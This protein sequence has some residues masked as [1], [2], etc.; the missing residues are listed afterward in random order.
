MTNEYPPRPCQC[1][2]V[3]HF[4]DMPQYDPNQHAYLMQPAGNRQAAYVGPVCDP[5]ANSHYADVLLPDN[6]VRIRDFTSHGD[7]LKGQ[8]TDRNAGYQVGDWFT[9]RGVTSYP[10]TL[11]RELA[12]VKLEGE[13]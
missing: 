2:H 10:V 4:P 5:C 6:V 3:S 13:S 7:A 12:T 1:E 9:Y 8:A 11:P